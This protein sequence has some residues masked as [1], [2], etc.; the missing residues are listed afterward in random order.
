MSVIRV[1]FARRYLVVLGS[2]AQARQD[3]NMSSRCQALEREAA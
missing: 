2:H 1:P 3:V